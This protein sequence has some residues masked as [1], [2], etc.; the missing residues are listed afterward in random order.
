MWRDFYKAQKIASAKRYSKTLQQTLDSLKINSAIHIKW[1]TIDTLT[2]N[3]SNIMVL[4]THFPGQT[5]VPRQNN[6]KINVI[7]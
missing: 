3:P 4:K 6:W 7:K 2:L 1:Q 5:I